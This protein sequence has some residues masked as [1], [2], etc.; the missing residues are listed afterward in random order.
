LAASLGVSFEEL[1]KMALITAS[2]VEVYQQ[3]MMKMIH[4]P[5]QQV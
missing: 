1:E 5:L 2:S 4:S 3:Y